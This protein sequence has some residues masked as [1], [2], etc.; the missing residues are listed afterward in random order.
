MATQHTRDVELP[1]PYPVVLDAVARSAPTAG[2]TVNTVDPAR[3]MVFGVRSMSVFS[4]GENVTMQLGQ[5]APTAPTQ[6]RITSA[7]AFGLVDWGRN[8]KNV[9]AV[10]AALTAFLDQHAAASRLG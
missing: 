2:I 1:Y 9:D 7:L 6:L 4:W 10:L 5:T 3:G 8:R